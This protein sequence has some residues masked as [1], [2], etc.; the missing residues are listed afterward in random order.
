[1][2][3]QLT[4]DSLLDVDTVDEENDE[5]SFMAQS[6]PACSTANKNTSSG[7]G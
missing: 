5:L 3:D 4:S 1:M 6:V 2:G 7:T